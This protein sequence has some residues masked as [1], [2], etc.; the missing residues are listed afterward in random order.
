MPSL[1][2]E[3][4]QS[5]N[6]VPPRRDRRLSGHVILNH[7]KEGPYYVG[8]WSDSGVVAYET[9]RQL[10]EKGHEVAL[11]VMFDTANPSFQRQALKDAW[12][13]SRTEK[14]R[15]FFAELL[16]LKLDNVSTYVVD[17]VKEFLENERG[18]SQ[19]RH[20]FYVRLHGGTAEGPEQIL[21][22]AVSAYRPFPYAGRVSFFK[23]TE[24]PAG[25]AW[26]FSRGWTA[27]V[28]GE[29]QVFEVPGDH[30]T[31]FREPNVRTLASIML[32]NFSR[33]LSGKDAVG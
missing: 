28:T 22:Q 15:F 16:G 27:L 24:G 18:S 19:I 13:T 11:L 8:G 5:S 20:E 23:A 4:K 3:L 12:L 14:V 33:Q 10:T 30:R 21:H 6:T 25:P 9:A 32:D 31:M 17:K 7:Q 26:D 29:F 1:L 2:P